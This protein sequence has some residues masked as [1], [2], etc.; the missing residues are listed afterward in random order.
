MI[1]IV[2]KVFCF[3]T[4]NTY[5]PLLLEVLNGIFYSLKKER[6]EHYQVLYD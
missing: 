2:D 4:T 3:I 5:Y 6:L 1:F